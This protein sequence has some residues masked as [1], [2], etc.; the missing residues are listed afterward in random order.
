MG[1][2]HTDDLLHVN[3]ITTVSRKSRT[4]QARSTTTKYNREKQ[5]TIQREEI[6][7]IGKLSSEEITAQQQK[8]PSRLHQQTD[9]AALKP[10]IQA[11]LTSQESHNVELNPPLRTQKSSGM[12]VSDNARQTPTPKPDSPADWN[13]TTEESQVDVNQ[14][15]SRIV[16]TVDL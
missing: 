10:D 4:Q 16:H 13:P 5:S 9:I 15:N 1:Q 2:S 8:P 3:R 11:E 6:I 14:L 12:S 7:S